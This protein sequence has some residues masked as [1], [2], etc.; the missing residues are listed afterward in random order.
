MIRHVVTWKLNS[1]EESAKIADAATITAALAA[2]PAV[3]SEIKS[4]TVGP[5]LA[6]PDANWDLALVADYDDLDGL[7]AY[8]TH[9]EHLKAVA[10]IKPLVAQ[11]AAAD[12]EF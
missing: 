4:L 1:T 5:N 2:L 12:F 7:E 3:I 10:V 11:R 8:Q 9:P 6:Y